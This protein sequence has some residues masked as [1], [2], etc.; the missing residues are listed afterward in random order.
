MMKN[1]KNLFSLEHINKKK[2]EKS[3]SHVA[4][5]MKKNKKKSLQNNFFSRCHYYSFLIL[6]G[7]SKKKN[8]YIYFWVW[9]TVKTHIKQYIEFLFNAFFFLLC[10]NKMF[11]FHIFCMLLKDSL[12]HFFFSYLQWNLFG[13]KCYLIKYFASWKTSCLP[14]KSWTCSNPHSNM[15]SS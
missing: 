14:A 6:F 10:A 1:E 7:K 9:F 3:T 5:I 8:I 12:S 4:V 11:F 2:N 15:I 13:Q